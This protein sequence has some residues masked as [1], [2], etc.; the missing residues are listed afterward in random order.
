MTFSSSVLCILFPNYRGVDY[1]CFHW[2]RLVLG[3][4]GP[5]GMETKDSGGF[6]Q[7][8]AFAASPRRAL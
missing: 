2:C 1:F 7:Y 8:R 5:L 6:R 4:Q 3:L